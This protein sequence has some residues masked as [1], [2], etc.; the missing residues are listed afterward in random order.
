M[1]AEC[2]Y[3][4]QWDAISPLKIS[5]SHGGDLDSH[6]KHGSLGQPKSSTQ[7][8]SRS[9]Q[10]FF[11]GLNNEAKTFQECCVRSSLMSTQLCTE[12]VLHAMSGHEKMCHAPEFFTLH[13]INCCFYSNCCFS[14]SFTGSRKPEQ[15]SNIRSESVNN[16]GSGPATDSSCWHQ[17]GTENS[18]QCYQTLYT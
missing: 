18:S 5:P 3:T 2:P 12:W 10:P 7:T 4:L 16:E 1:T 6:L 17:Q 8:A 14:V 9:V 11:A 13:C 15:G